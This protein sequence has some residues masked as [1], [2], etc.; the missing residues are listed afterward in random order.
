MRVTP[1]SIEPACPPAKTAPDQNHSPQ[2]GRGDA[3][4]GLSGDS[5]PD[6]AGRAYFARPPSPH[7]RVRCAPFGR[8]T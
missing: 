2:V 5:P 8:E 3:S 4:D 6:T 7:G 1:E